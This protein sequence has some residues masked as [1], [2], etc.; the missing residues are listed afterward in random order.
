MDSLDLASCGGSDSTTFGSYAAILN[1]LT[2][3]LDTRDID[4][5]PGKDRMF[6]TPR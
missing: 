5:H 4:L 6:R 3:A 2:S 1:F